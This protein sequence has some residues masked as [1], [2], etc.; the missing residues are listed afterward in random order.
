MKKIFSVTLIGILLLLMCLSCYAHQGRLDSNGG[1]YIQE[2]DDCVGYHYHDGIYTGW[3]LNLNTFITW[4]CRQE[5]DQFKPFN[6]DVDTCLGE[7]TQVEFDE[8]MNVITPDTTETSTPTNT[9][10]TTIT[11]TSTPEPQTT[12]PVN[13]T[14]TPN[15]PEPTPTS[16]ELPQTGGEVPIISSIISMIMVAGGGL[17]LRFNSKK[18]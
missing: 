6:P 9:S 13:E 4:D 12:N 1:H 8:N 15:T 18:K 7:W 11:A 5:L 2:N 16:E 17:L 10:T 14:I 3:Q